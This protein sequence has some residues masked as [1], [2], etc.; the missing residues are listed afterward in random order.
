MSRY[1]L[2]IANATLPAAQDGD[3]FSSFVI[4]QSI[5]PTPYWMLAIE[6]TYTMTSSPTSF[7]MGISFAQ[8]IQVD[9][10][11]PPTNSITGLIEFSQSFGDDSIIFSEPIPQVPPRFVSGSTVPQ[12]LSKI[13]AFNGQASSRFVVVNI[14][15]EDE[16]FTLDIR[17]R[18]EAI[19]APINN[20]SPFKLTWGDGGWNATWES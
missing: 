14:S 7:G 12:T 2:N 11:A 17:V 13:Y 9:N 8:G 20:N 18:A 16:L 10:T 1:V 4:D 3:N 19:E 6:G 5:F 15:N